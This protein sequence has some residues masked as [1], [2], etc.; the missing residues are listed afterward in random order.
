MDASTIDSLMAKHVF[1]SSNGMQMPY[2]L[3][4][5]IIESTEKI[6][7]V[8]F[9][10]GRGDRG[11]DNSA[12]IYH[13]AGIIVNANSL[14]KAEIQSNFPCYIL[15]PQCSDK[16]EN[17]EWA[18]WVGNSPETPFKGLGADSTYTMSPSPSESGEAALELIEQTIKDKNIDANR[19][20]IIGLS[21]GG[22]G[23]WEFT[24]R[25]P[26][27]FAGAIPMA[28]YSDPNQLEKIKHIPF[29]IFH[30]SIDK[31]NPVTGSRTMFKLLSD[32]NADVRY[33]EYVDTGHGESFKKAFNEA[34]LIPWL[35]SKKRKTN[36][37][38]E[39]L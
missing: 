33:T 1:S 4:S 12:Q 2:R 36:S 15:V 38:Q 11:R 30:G 22:F 13:E 21:M 20:Y 5:P 16:T 27:V 28:G 25:K 3:F 29:W 39:K 26:H 6:P 32:S 31:W 23:T 18:K 37:S 34:E 8:I 10:H 14:L 7:L 17:E 19:V 35:F 24:A 9:L